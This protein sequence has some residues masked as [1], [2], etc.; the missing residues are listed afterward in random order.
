MPKQ[1]KSSVDESARTMRIDIRPHSVASAP[2]EPVTG[3]WGRLSTPE[4]NTSFVARPRVRGGRKSSYEK[5][6]ESIY[7]AVLLTD[8]KGRVIDFN[9]RAADFFL[10]DNNELLGM[11]V[12]DLI[13]GADEG[14]LRAIKRNLRD[15]K[16]TLIE[17]RC[18]R[19]DDTSFPAEIAA[20]RVDLDEQGQLAF[21]VRDI[22]VRKRAQEDLEDAVTR[23][24]AHDRARS[25]F[26]TNVSHELRTPL[27]SMIYAVNNMLR[28]VVGWLPERAVRYLERL[29][30]DC[31][32]LLAT[33]NDILDLRKIENRSLTLA[34]TRVPL[35]RLV[36]G[37]VESL[38]VQADEKG[39]RVLFDIHDRQL[40]VDC[41]PQKMERVILN[42]IGNA[43]KF[44]PKGGE[45]RVCIDADEQQPD[46]VLVTVSDTG[47][48][49][50]ADAIAKVTVRYFKVGEQPSGSGLGLAISK[51]IV[52]LHGG[53]IEIK[54]PVPGHEK[55]TAVYVS[56]PTTAPP[57]VLVVDDEPAI[58]AVVQAQV[59][60]RGYRVVTASSAEEALACCDKE[61]ISV[62]VLD[63]ILP[64]I[65]GTQLILQLRHRKQSMRLPIIVLTGSHIGRAK[66][67]ILSSFAIPTISK[68]WREEEL[69]DR[70]EGAFF[71][72]TVF[73]RQVEGSAGN[74]APEQDA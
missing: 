7:D 67:E 42:V 62:M 51:E 28:G 40:F 66:A 4:Q 2:A 46:H 29:D 31:R 32:R 33:V 64:D 47:L 26:V 15:H 25:E 60:R 44:T 14:V 24:E 41:D 21:F 72:G 1:K 10:F 71:G 13:S 53:S 17:A 35:S 18:L 49:I 19:S 9:A 37:C 36:L 43:I 57:T 30:A 16:Y 34:R 6:L 63:L 11:S 50:P 70:I 38:R 74:A 12:V 54:S 69:L 22:S 48:G 58:R 8:H 3:A 39:L 65:D 73:G 55:G 59:E 52:E 20:N 68:P 56:L 61:P 5:L 23:L 27:T 45:I